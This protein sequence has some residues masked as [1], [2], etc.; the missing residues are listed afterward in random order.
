MILR[1]F[2][3]NSPLLAIFFP[4]IVSSLVFSGR[5]ELWL[6]AQSTPLHWM[7]D[8]MLCVSFIIVISL[9]A[10]IINLTYNK[11]ELFHSQ[12]FLTG[13]FY[14]V[15][16]SICGVQ[17]GDL[18][19]LIAQSFFLI[20]IYLS[21]SLFRQKKIAHHLFSASIFLGLAS[22][23]DPNY[24]IFILLIL[25]L[26]FWNRPI[27]LK[28]LILIILGFIIPV[29][30]WICWLW[31][32][33]FSLDSIYHLIHFTSN[34]PFDYPSTTLLITLGF[35]VFFA[36]LS[37]TQKEDRQSNK[38]VQSKQYLALLFVIFLLDQIILFFGFHQLTMHHLLSIA[39]VL[40]LSHYWTHYRT[41]LIAPFAF[42][43]FILVLTLEY[44][45]WI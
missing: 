13:A 45:H 21:F 40:L 31:L 32:N 39:P 2:T 1:S 9:N 19:A 36:A 3:Q 10:F 30:Y 6:G 26:S 14:S 34:N 24:L 18:L 20:S 8:L 12:V 27:S 43:T 11:G 5:Q 4:I 44:F 17:T 29:I 35:V 28:D 37:L 7:S 42:Y 38:T 16:A 23:L 25:I 33:A 15:V 22:L 41:S